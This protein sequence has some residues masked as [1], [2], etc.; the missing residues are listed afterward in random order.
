MP[1]HPQVRA[2]LQAMTDAG[3]PAL[4]T[5]T[6]E[7][8]RAMRREQ[9]LRW[10]LRPD[11]GVSRE[12]R[13]LPGPAG[14]IRMRTYAPSREP[15]FSGLI[16]YH[17]GG[18]ILGDL[19]AYD[20]VCELLAR[21][22]GCKVVS[23][24]YRLAPEHPFPAGLD[25]TD[26]SLGWLLA[27]AASLSID[28]ARVA[29]AGDSAGANLL[30]VACNRARDR[31]DRLPICQ[32]LVY[33]VTGPLGCTDS[34]TA[35]SEGYFLTERSMHWFFTQYAPFPGALE[36]PLILPLLIDDLRGMPPALIVTAEYDPLR[37]EGEAYARRLQEAGVPV[38][39]TRYPGMIHGFLALLPPLDTRDDL[40][41]EMAAYLRN[42]LDSV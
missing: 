26:A 23:V 9:R 28:P 11:P 7:E 24:D 33:P 42:V 41:R 10:S 2:F 36:N 5:L 35:F 38:T 21:A 13:T 1:L 14:E 39:C 34:Q 3:I 8:A 40:V 27:N 30:T 4:D 29:A 22:A 18:W 12:N 25:D 16:Y 32:V 37:D 17:G 20:H 31:G 19:D 15:P 6:A